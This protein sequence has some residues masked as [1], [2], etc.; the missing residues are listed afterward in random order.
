MRE[1]ALA[2][3]QALDIRCTG[4]D[5]PAGML[6]GGN[7]QKV[8]VAQALTLRPRIL[9]VSEPTRG[10]DIGAKQLLLNVL[11]RLNREQG[12]TILFTS[13][14]LQ[15]LRS[16]CDRIAIVTRGRIAGILPPDAPEAEFGL[17]MSGMG[18]IRSG[19]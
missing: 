8:C 1:N 2:F 18:G 13:S 3:I 19:L 17:L 11:L 12:I 15:E 16:V 10:I 5:Q 6:S 14:E 4:P 9:L 7:Q